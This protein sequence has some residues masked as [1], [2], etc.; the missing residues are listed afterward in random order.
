MLARLVIEDECKLMDYLMQDQQAKV[1][2]EAGFVAGFSG[3]VG[4]DW[5]GAKTQFIAGIQLAMAGPDTASPQT[6]AAPQ[7]QHWSRQNVHDFLCDQ[8]AQ[9]VAGAPLLV[10]I[11]FAF[12]HPFADCDSYFPDCANS[13][14][15]A[16]ALWQLVD[17]VNGDMPHFYGG[18][19]FRHAVWGEYYLAPPDFD[20]PRYATRR[21]LTEIVAKAS[22]RSP[23]PTFKAVG[24][25]NV[26]TGSMAGMRLLHQLR[27]TLG[28]QLAIW[29]F[30]DV[31]AKPDTV[32]LVLVEI[33]PSYYFYRV[34]MSPAKRAA[35]RADF[36]TKALGF[37]DSDGVDPQFV[38]KGADADEADAIIAAAALRY[39]ARHPS[40][41]SQTMFDLP[42]AIGL[43]ARQEGWIFGV[44]P[45]NAPTC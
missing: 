18:A 1:A 16:A 20:A 6:I 40:V 35:A 12:A 15:D 30:D 8:A 33:F 36:L 13:P 5:S 9:T 29:P 11:D 34:G 45:R 3:F 10:G 4:I 28:D 42:D 32:R 37:Y 23:S 43:T 27:L 19:M 25:D 38:A 21:R 2:F 17:Q 7:Q 31:T 44:D 41:S 22:G 39:F 14:R 24:A 26:S